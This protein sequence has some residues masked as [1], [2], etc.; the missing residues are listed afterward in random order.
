TTR[1]WLERA[2][3]MR[4]ETGGEYPHT[5]VLDGE[6]LWIRAP[7]LGVIEQDV[8]GDTG[9]AG[10]HA[11]LFSP[12]TIAAGAEL[13]LG[14]PSTVAGR[15]G[16]AVHASPRTQGEVIGLGLGAAGADEFELVVDAERGVLLR[17]EARLEGAPFDIVEFVEIS[18]DEQLDPS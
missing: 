13:M 1:L 5:H 14:G 3:R 8:G 9:L 10:H 12:L 16:I 15:A 2:G 7:A 11:I 18:F 4:E 6:K 17:I